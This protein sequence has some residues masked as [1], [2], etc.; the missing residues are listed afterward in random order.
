MIWFSL[1]CTSPC[2]APVPH[3]TL[4]MTEAH[5]MARQKSTEPS[6]HQSEPLFSLLTICVTV[7]VH[8]W[9][10]VLYALIIGSG[11]SR[12]C[13]PLYMYINDFETEKARGSEPDSYYFPSSFVGLLLFSCIPACLILSL[14]AHSR[15][16]GDSAS[17]CDCLEQS[18]HLGP[19]WAKST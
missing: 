14:L 18:M 6:D 13:I 8:E 17:S 19:D 16:R 10:N 5:P 1:S 4:V 12:C 9:N 3:P 7:N 11:L 2:T 15:V